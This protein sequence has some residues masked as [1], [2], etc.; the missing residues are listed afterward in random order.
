MQSIRNETITVSP[1]L[2]VKGL[3][4]YFPINSTIGGK[5]GYV[6]AVNNVEFTL[7]KNETLGLVGESGCGKSTTGRTILRLTEPTG[8]QALYNGQDL[9]QLKQREFHKMRSKMQMVFQDPHSSINPKHRI[10][11]AIEEPM[12]IHKL[13]NSK[14]RKERA[15]ELLYKVGLRE[16]Q[17]YKYPHEFSG[18]QRQRIGIARALALN[19]EILICDEP[20]SALDVSIQSQVINLMEELQ[21]QFNLSY[22]FIAH[23]LSVVRHISDHIGVMYLGELVEKAPTDE[24]FSHPLHPYTKALLSSIPVAN[25]EFKRERIVLKG[26]IPSPINP[27]SGCKFHKRCQYAME[28]CKTEAPIL[29]ELENNHSVACHLYV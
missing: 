8:G 17:Y 2:E 25:P 20:V 13:Y 5:K 3:K 24:L 14:E 22:I 12:K 23:D 7:H 1:L 6:Q 19:P 21:E 4:K 15:M 26:D 16:D 27:P 29:T 18:G 10:G 28:R 9:F 11:R